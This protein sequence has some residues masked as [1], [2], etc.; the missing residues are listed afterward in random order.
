MSNP[1]V[2]GIDHGNG[3]MKTAR[4]CFPCG[5]KMQETEPSSLFAK[6]VIEYKG[7]YYSLTPTAYSYQTDKTTDN[8]AI[9]LTLFSIAKEAVARAEEGRE[10]FDFKKDF[11]G[12]NGKEVVLGVGLPPA[13]FEKQA[14][15]FKEYLFKEFQNG[16]R[17][18]Y[19]GKSFNFYIKDIYLYPQDYAAAVIYRNDLLTTY[20]T[21]YCID[22]GDGTVDLV[23]LEEGIPE[24]ET[25]LSREFGMS[26]LRSMVIDDVIND[27]GL[28]L[29]HKNV[30]DFLAGKPMALAPDFATRI[31][32][33]IDKTCETFTTE[34]INQ[35]HSKISDFRVYPTIFCGGGALALKKYID[36]SGAFGIVDYIDDIH[37]NAVGY[38]T[39][40]KMQLGI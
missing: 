17:F 3:N 6:D 2:I 39:I 20:S 38:E 7:V 27:H 14:K 12:Y 19:N 5:F 1:I 29:T 8:K 40:T 31:T 18:S 23:G 33:R 34:L 24:K 37:A 16:V 36:K 10:G 26:K 35:L 28:T 4:T 11:Y 15:S 30:N 21:C 22:I 13:H 25:V 32:A 9:I